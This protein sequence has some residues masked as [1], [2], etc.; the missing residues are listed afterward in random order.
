M[1]VCLFVFVR[2]SSFCWFFPS[3]FN[4]I[5]LDRIWPCP[6]LWMRGDKGCLGLLM[7]REGHC[8]SPSLPAGSGQDRGGVRVRPVC[9]DNKVWPHMTNCDHSHCSWPCLRD[10]LA[11]ILCT[12]SSWMVHVITRVA[13]LWGCGYSDGLTMH[14][15]W[16][17][18]DHKQ[19]IVTFAG[20]ANK[21]VFCFF[22]SASRKKQPISN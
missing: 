14:K 9:K 7:G 2:T 6:Q 1:S 11:K 4:F 15:V 21:F 13:L 8:K 5:S 20:T 3:S 10:Y 16:L 18:A 12:S 22:L 17:P 19:V